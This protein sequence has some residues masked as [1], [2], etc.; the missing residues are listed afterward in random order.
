VVDYVVERPFLAAG[1]LRIEEPETR[2]QEIE[3][4]FLHLK[5]QALEA[6]QLMPQV[7]EGLVGTVQNLD[8]PVRPNG[9][10]HQWRKDPSRQ[11]SVG[12]GS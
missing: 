7:P 4:R 8:I 2:T 3:A 9:A 12:P 1:V 6:L 5:N 11:L 10:V